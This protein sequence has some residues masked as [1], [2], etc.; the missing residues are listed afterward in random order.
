MNI[1]ET[2][3]NIEK[4]IRRG[5]KVPFLFVQYKTKCVDSPT[6]YKTNNVIPFYVIDKGWFNAVPDKYPFGCLCVPIRAVEGKLDIAE[7][8]A[9]NA[10]LAKV[11]NNVQLSLKL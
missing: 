4:I 10:R 1:F 9:K 3:S 8:C 6:G 11:D 5:A 2:V 7:I